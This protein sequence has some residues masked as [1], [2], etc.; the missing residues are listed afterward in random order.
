MTD[1]QAKTIWISIRSGM[2]V[3]CPPNGCTWKPVTEAEVTEL[4]NLTQVL[5]AFSPQAKACLKELS[6][7]F[8]RVL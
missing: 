4:V 2:W 3:K 5:P 6:R 8:G 1:L 7:R